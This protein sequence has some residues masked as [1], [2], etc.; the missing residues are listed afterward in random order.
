ME[1]NFLLIYKN[2]KKV[3]GQISRHAILQSI[4]LKLSFYAPVAQEMDKEMQWWQWN[5]KLDISKYKGLLV[6]WLLVFRKL[7]DW[8]WILQ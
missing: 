8:W 1:L 2:T 5:I 7:Q 4:V 3:T 6:C